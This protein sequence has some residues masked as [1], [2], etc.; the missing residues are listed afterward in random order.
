M[1]V[2]LDLLINFQGLGKS[3]TDDKKD[4]GKEQEKGK[5]VQLIHG[6][7]HGPN[8]IIHRG[9]KPRKMLGHLLKSHKFSMVSHIVFTFV[10]FHACF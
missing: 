10:L 6:F 2:G 5:Q 9:V 4:K 7:K 1:S 8:Y 3:K